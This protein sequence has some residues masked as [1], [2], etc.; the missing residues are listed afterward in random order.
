M[1]DDINQLSA[2]TV[3]DHLC[4]GPGLLE[5]IWPEAKSR[6]SLRALINWRDLGIIPYIKLA[7][8]VFYD[9]ARW[10]SDW[11]PRF[12]KGPTGREGAGSFAWHLATP[13]KPTARLR[14][15][16]AGLRVQF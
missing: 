10:T 3:S 12:E 2:P 13:E 11:E 1:R 15:R 7:R 9:P 5:A 6:P 4:D 14:C 8:R 16:N